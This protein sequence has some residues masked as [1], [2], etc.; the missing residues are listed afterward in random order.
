MGVCQWIVVILWAL[1]FLIHL[2]KDGEDMHMDYSATRAGLSILIHFIL[3][4][5]GG[6]FS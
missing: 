3:L 2:S 6:F 5:F 1:K 4:Y